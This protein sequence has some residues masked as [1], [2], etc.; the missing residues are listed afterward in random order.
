[1][2]IFGSNFKYLFLFFKD[3]FGGFLGLY[4]ERIGQWADRKGGDRWGETCVK[5][6]RFGT[7]KGDVDAPGSLGLKY[8]GALMTINFY[9]F[10]YFGTMLS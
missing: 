8:L 7:L 9:I 5:V 10:G 3:I 4:L 2:E 6:A 1:M